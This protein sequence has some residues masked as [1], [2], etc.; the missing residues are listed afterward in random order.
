MTE[1]QALI[2]GAV[3]GA[4][5]KA[6]AEGPFLIDVTPQIDADGNYLPEISVVGRESGEKL[7]V[8]IEVEA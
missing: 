4:L 5:L 2:T 3:T 1:F 7:R 8:R 6:D